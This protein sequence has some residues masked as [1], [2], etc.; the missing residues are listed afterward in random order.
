RRMAI[1]KAFVD[2]NYDSIFTDPQNL[3]VYSAKYAPSRA[4]GFF[5]LLRN[6]DIISL[7]LKEAE[8]RVLGLG[9]GAGSELVAFAALA[10][11]SSPA[12]VQC[13]LVDF[14]EYGDILKLLDDSVRYKWHLDTSQFTMNFHQCDILNESNAPLL[15]QLIAST[16]FITAFF[17]LNE[18]F[19][20]KKRTMQ[21]ITLLVKN[22]K[23]GC[24]LLI[25]DSAGSFSNLEVGG[26][27]YPVYTMFDA[28]KTHFELVGGSE[29]QWYRYPAHLQYPLDLENMRYFYRL[30]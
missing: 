24:H 8:G 28:M 16:N 3:P 1:K 20:D 23:P 30:Y 18:L 7:A 5:T 17:V 21:V 26:R 11:V 22:M 25:V 6:T 19:V 13:E 29:S 4:L 27:T 9:A 15:A 10:A 2:R 12:S 14:G